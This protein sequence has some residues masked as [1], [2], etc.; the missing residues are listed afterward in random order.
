[1]VGVIPYQGDRGG[2]R[3]EK[4]FCGETTRVQHDDKTR[5]RKATASTK[6]WW[7]LKGT[8]TMNKTHNNQQQT[9]EQMRVTR[10]SEKIKVM[11]RSEK[12]KGERTR[13]ENTTKRKIGRS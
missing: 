6:P 10:R 2:Y 7:Q 9:Q 8:I 4:L 12:I 11:R 3:R 5:R 13:K 1:L